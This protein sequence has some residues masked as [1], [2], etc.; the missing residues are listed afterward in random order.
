MAVRFAAHQ[1]VTYL[2]DPEFSDS[3]GLTAEISRKFSMNGTRY[4]YIKNKDQRR[5]LIMQFI[6]TRQKAL[7]FHAFIQSYYRFQIH[8]TDHNGIEWSGYF[9]SN[10][11]NFETP[12]RSEHQNIQIEFE[13][14]KQ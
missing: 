11:F 2:P 5:K 10:P 6:L 4:T 13:G 14:I 9:T 7:E 8:L 3:E 1:T 12:Y